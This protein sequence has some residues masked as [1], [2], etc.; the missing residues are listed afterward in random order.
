MLTQTGAALAKTQQTYEHILELSRFQTSAST[1]AGLTWPAG[2]EV[3]GTAGR[4][5]AGS[6]CTPFSTPARLCGR[7]IG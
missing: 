2:R 3:C 6:G 4:C 1:K 5:T 7:A